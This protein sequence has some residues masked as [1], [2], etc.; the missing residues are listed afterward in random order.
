MFETRQVFVFEGPAGSGKSYLIDR[1]AETGKATKLELPI[2]IPRPRAYLG[3]EGE[4]LAEI[5][6]HVSATQFTLGHYNKPILVDRW[7]VSRSVYQGLRE[8]PVTGMDYMNLR[9]KAMA[10]MSAGLDQVSEIQLSHFGTFQPLKIT[11]V[12]TLPAQG[13]IA[14][15]RNSGS[16]QYYYST[17]AE[18]DRY[19]ATWSALSTAK[20]LL[21]SRIRIRGHSLDFYLFSYTG[22]P[23]SKFGTF[24]SAWKNLVQA[25]CPG[26]VAEEVA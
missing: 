2:D 25:V 24:P 15:Y 22:P 17:Q 14:D 9:P 16:K 3:L 11:I 26:E 19:W 5:K 18:L 10:A 7:R 6:D 21:N 1:L 20:D 12:F 4:I 13:I 8:Q 23:V